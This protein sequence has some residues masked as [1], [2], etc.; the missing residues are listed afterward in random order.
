MRQIVTEESAAVNEK[1]CK[2][3]GFTLIELV[4]VITILGIL[5]AFAMP[6]FA[7]LEG[8][9][10]VGGDPRRSRAASAPARRCAHA[11]WL[12]QGSPASTVTME[13]N[14]DHDGQRLPQPRDDR[15]HARRRHGLHVHDAGATGVFTT[16]HARRDRHLLGDVHAGPGQR[17]ARTSWRRR[18]PAERRTAI[19][20]IRTEAPA[21]ASRH[22][23]A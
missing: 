1:D 16:V 8:Q 10:R 5:A 13:G 15:R 9:A 19:G 6:R 12:A 4:V 2:Q 22:A 21:G 3:G 7:S 11:L 18:R 17:S 14:V 23:S 20:P